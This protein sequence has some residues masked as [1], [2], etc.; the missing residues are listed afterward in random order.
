MTT[1]TTTQGTGKVPPP[2]EYLEGTLDGYLDSL[3]LTKDSRQPDWETLAFQTKAGP[4]YRRAQLRYIGSGAT[5]DHDSDSR[6]IPSVH[7]TFSN[8][9]LPPGCEGPEHV[10]HDVEEVF[11]VVEGT[12]QFGVH[13]DGQVATRTLGPRDMLVVPPG[14]PRSL[15]N[16][17]DTDGIIC[18]VIG[19][20]KPMLPTYPETSPMHGVTRD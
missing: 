3:V 6:I 9:L 1:T 12:I 7:F 10:H 4:Q 18:V 11:Y 13:R 2:P 15:K 8:M 20:Q 16:V 5:G 19:A 14:V 17:G